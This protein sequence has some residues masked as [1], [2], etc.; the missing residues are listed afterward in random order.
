MRGEDVEDYEFTKNFKVVDG[1]TI[2][3]VDGSKTSAPK[4]TQTVEHSEEKCNSMTDAN[5]ADKV[6]THNMDLNGEHVLMNENTHPASPRDSQ[7]SPDTE[8]NASVEG[9]SA[10]AGHDGED[11]A[12]S[13]ETEAECTCVDE[14]NDDKRVQYQ[15]TK[16]RNCRAY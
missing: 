14:H 8:R 7:T 12:Q 2:M 3:D 10:S 9:N 15:R 1:Q 6:D 5:S 16:Q 4:E 11:K 13:K